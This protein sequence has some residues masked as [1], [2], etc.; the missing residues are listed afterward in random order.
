MRKTH[1]IDD[2][3]VASSDEK[4]VG[5]SEG[6]LRIRFRDMHIIVNGRRCMGNFP[7]SKDKY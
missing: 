4:Y 1:L 6:P 5:P 2:K 3:D 7:P